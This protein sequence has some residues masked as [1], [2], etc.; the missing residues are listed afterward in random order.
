MGSQSM[1]TLTH[2]CSHGPKAAWEFLL[3]SSGQAYIWKINWRN[4][5]QNTTNIFAYLIWRLWSKVWKIQMTISGWRGWIISTT[6]NPCVFPSTSPDACIIIPFPRWRLFIVLLQHHCMLV[7][8]EK[9]FIS[10]HVWLSEMRSPA[11]Y[12]VMRVAAVFV[13]T[14][15]HDTIELTTNT[16][17]ES[18]KILNH[19][20]VEINFFTQVSY[21]RRGIT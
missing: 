10:R 7:F 16:S 20:R 19:E 13:R 1:Y 3:K 15:K 17:R 14:R 9:M 21:G 5:Y 2:Y 6:Q 4:V 11:A 18:C 8:P 12:R